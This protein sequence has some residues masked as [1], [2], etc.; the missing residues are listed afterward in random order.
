MAKFKKGESGNPNGRPKG[1]P[2]KSTDQLRGMFQAFLETNWDT[3]QKDFDKLDARDRLQFI[4]RVAKLVLPPPLDD[5]HRLTDE[6]FET[7][8]ERI[9]NEKQKTY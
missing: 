3:V 5:L 6:Q 2:N 1:S 8:I 9:K 7:L 4:E